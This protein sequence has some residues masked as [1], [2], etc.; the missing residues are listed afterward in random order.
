VGTSLVYQSA[1][2][3]DLVMRLLYGWHHADRDRAIAALIHDGASVVDLCCGPGFLYERHLRRKG[4][5][6][7][8]LDINP[9]FI[10]RVARL[11]ARAQ[12]RDLR[13]DEPLPEADFIVMQASLYQFLPDVAPVLARMRAAARHSVIVAEPIRNLATGRVPL[14]SA[15][16]R[17][18][19]DP[20]LGRCARRFDERSLE[21]ALSNPALRTHTALIPGGREQVHVL[22]GANR[23][24]PATKEDR[25]GL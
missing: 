7:L 8:G 4:V 2:L 19:A 3:Y 12:V 6:Y 11:G 14:V 23:G 16:A 10:R 9:R 22:R 25:T 15:L 17:R 13:R 20:G 1:T 5:D 21:A 24:R 18:M